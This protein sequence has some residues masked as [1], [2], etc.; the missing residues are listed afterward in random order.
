MLTFKHPFTA[1]V[2][3]PTSCGKTVFV[4]R[5]IDHVSKM[6]DPPP[7]KIVY[8]YGEYQ[9]VFARYLRV[10]FHQGFRIRTSYTVIDDLLQ[11]TNK[12]VVNLFIKGSHYR[13][14]SIMYMAQNLFR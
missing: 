9:Q 13:N 10:V 1:I 12:T 6:I 8:C 14:V 2:A 5:L 7:S 11:E 4:F 3:G